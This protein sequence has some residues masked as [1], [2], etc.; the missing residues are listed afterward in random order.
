MTSENIV[1]I[2]MVVVF[3]VYNSWSRSRKKK[4]KLE[5]QRME[6]NSQGEQRQAEPKPEPEVEQRLETNIDDLLKQ[7]L[8][9]QKEEPIIPT[10]KPEP[11]PD[12]VEVP[13]DHVQT[14]EEFHDSESEFVEGKSGLSQE[15]V[16]QHEHKESNLEDEPTPKDREE[17]N[18]PERKGKD[19]VQA[20]PYAIVKN[21]KQSLFEFDL[22]KAVIYSEIL[23]RK[24]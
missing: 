10:P 1:Y 16:D 5:Q 21:A 9:P 6:S 14:E 19:K 22:E 15:Y 2:V 24:F 7:W 12:P 18:I 17:L 4:R 20:K 3:L 13:I 11:I 8:G 23:K